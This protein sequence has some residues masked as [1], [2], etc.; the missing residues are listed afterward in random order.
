MRSTPTA[1]ADTNNFYTPV[2]KKY[3]NTG[4][5]STLLP[6]D[7]KHSDYM[8]IID[9][10][11][12]FWAL[13][14]KENLGDALSEGKLLAKYEEKRE[15][16]HREIDTLR[17]R[18]APTAVYFNPTERCNLNCKYCYI[19]E[20]LRRSGDHM[21][22][23]DLI[24]ALEILKNY[25]ESHLPGE[26]KAQIIFHGSEPMLNK[27]A[28]FDAI[29]RFGNTFDFGIQTNGTLLDKESI[30]FIKSKGI[31]LGLSLDAHLPDIS[32]KT[33]TTWS[34]KGI[35]KKVVHVIEELDGYYNFNVICT[36]NNK[37]VCYLK[38]IVRF[39]HE[40]NIPACMLN[41]IRC[42]QAGAREIKPSE[43]L[44]ADHYIEALDYSFELYRQTGRKLIVVNFANIMISILA[45]LARKLMCDI[46]PC[47]GGRSFF[48]VAADGSLFPCSEFIGLP[49]FNGGNIFEDSIADILETSAFRSVTG[50]L[51]E[52]IEPCKRCAIRHFCGSPCPAEAYS[53]T[54][55]INTRGAFCSFYEEQ[56][57]YAFRQIAEGREEAYLWDEWDKDTETIV[58]ISSL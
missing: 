39:F 6:I 21:S 16:L 55:D 12:A 5:G 35:F 10:D 34:G 2:S 29:E 48:A 31:A 22:R 17:F 27:D 53:T 46:S 50:R 30:K 13:V 33:R 4:E 56:V 36:I 43:S 18:L 25:F 19:P 8:A 37:N 52:K 15:E 47:G 41:P 7:I 20:E 57:R 1:L 49:E 9:P 38:D 51:V 23:K 3:A 24:V 45:P 32:D 42:T 58:D 14:K 44:F 54:G 26:R 28:V 40:L 11:T